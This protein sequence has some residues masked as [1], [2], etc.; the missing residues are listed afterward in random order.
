[1]R[2]IGFATRHNVQPPERKAVIQINRI[3]GYQL[4]AVRQRRVEKQTEM[5]IDLG[6]SVVLSPDC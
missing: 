2:P 4:K 1:M 5:P 3:S 6:T